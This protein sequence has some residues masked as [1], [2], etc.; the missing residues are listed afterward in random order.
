[1]CGISGIF[2]RSNL[3]IVD[4][5]VQ[6]GASGVGA[7]VDTGVYST[8]DDD[9]NLGLIWD[10]SDSRFKLYESLDDPSSEE[11]NFNT[12]AASTLELG[13]LLVVKTATSSDQET[14]SGNFTSNVGSISHTLTLDGDLNDDASASIT[15]TSDKVL[16][17]S[18]VMG[19]SNKNADIRIHTVDAGSFICE[20]T[21]KS[22]SAFAN[23]TTIVLNFVIL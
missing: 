3:E 2:N 8:L 23:N 12:G 6:I 7:L 1:M 20:I 21:N 13:R 15:V 11:F 14:S 4:T 18:V 17:T 16:A 22:G 5:L 19:S 10:R 9:E